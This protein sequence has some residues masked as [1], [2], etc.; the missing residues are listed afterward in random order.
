[1]HTVQ[2]AL[3]CDAV[4]LQVDPSEAYTRP[5]A[6]AGQSTF[7]CAVS[8]TAHQWMQCALLTL[9]AAWGAQLPQTPAL[10]RIRSPKTA[11]TWQEHG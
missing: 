5:R 9:S 11:L 10:D 4:Q 8:S 2:I 7:H 1:M 6:G 3:L